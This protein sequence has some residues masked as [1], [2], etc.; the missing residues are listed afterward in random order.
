MNSLVILAKSKFIDLLNELYIIPGH[1]CMK[2]NKC[3]KGFLE[4]TFRWINCLLT[5]PIRSTLTAWPRKPKDKDLSDNTYD[6]S[7]IFVFHK[8]FIYN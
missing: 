6:I 4:A 7:K 5:L 3:C 8:H 1:H 2:T